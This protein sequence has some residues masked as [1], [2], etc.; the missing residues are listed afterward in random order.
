M[1]P[2]GNVTVMERRVQRWANKNRKQPTEA[3]RQLEVILKELFPRTGDVQ[4]QWIFGRRS[5]P[6]IFD[7]FIPKVR[8]GIEV[9]GSIHD[10]P[11]VKAKDEA[12]AAKARSIKITV[13]RISN[14]QVFNSNPETIKQIIGCWYREADQHGQSHQRRPR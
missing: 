7:F 14:E 6:Y 12:K 5:A 4:V 8:L 13:R 9:D 2:S 1:A 11:D 3:E 10:R